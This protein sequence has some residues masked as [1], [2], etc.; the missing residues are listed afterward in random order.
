MFRSNESWILVMMVPAT[1]NGELKKVIEEKAKIANIK[2]K[3]VEKAG[4][5]LSAY[6]K[7]YD[8]T[9]MKSPCIEKD[10][11]ICTNTTK[12]TRNTPFQA[13][14]S[15]SIVNLQLASYE[16]CALYIARSP[17]ANVNFQP[18]SK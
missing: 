12:M 1:P 15:L 14:E 6:L 10:C 9:N 3:I 2:V 7:K 16:P 18:T 8:K 17:Q 11:L 4:T 5:K 13:F